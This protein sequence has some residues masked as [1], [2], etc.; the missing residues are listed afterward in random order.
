ML[1]HATVFKTALATKLR[2]NQFISYF[3]INRNEMHKNNSKIK[4]Q[5]KSGSVTVLQWLGFVRTLIDELR[6]LLASSRPFITI[7]AWRQLQAKYG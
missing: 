2:L 6:K 4:R 5:G 7:A 3:N 1:H